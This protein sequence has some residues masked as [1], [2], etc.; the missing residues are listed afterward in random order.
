MTQ[1]QFCKFHTDLTV[2]KWITNLPENQLHNQ[3]Y[4]ACDYTI[5]NTLVNTVPDSFALNEDNSLHILYDIVT[6]KANPAAHQLKFSSLLQS[7]GE[8]I[9]DFV[10]WLK[11]VYLFVSSAVQMP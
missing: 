11:S 5:H 6:K 3:L 7:L 4:S 8:S 9:N 2:F 10:V 1:P